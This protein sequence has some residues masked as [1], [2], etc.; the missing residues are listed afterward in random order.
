MTTSQYLQ[1]P[2]SRICD[3]D[4]ATLALIFHHAG[5]SHVNLW[6]THPDYTTL[7]ACALVARTWRRPAQM[8]LYRHIR[9]HS[10]A[11]ML[12][13]RSRESRRLIEAFD[14]E[15]LASENQWGIDTYWLLDR[16]GN[17]GSLKGFGIVYDP[18]RGATDGQAQRDE[19]WLAWDIL[20]HPALSRIQSLCCKAE[21]MDPVDTSAIALPLTHLTFGRLP[22][23]HGTALHQ[24]LLTS[25]NSSLH[26]ISLDFDPESASKPALDDLIEYFQTTATT[27]KYL[28]FLNKPNLNFLMSLHSKMNAI[29]MPSFF[30]VTYPLLPKA[31]A[32]FNVLCLACINNG[33]SLVE[34][35]LVEPPYHT[36]QDLPN[37]EEHEALVLR[38]LAAF[39][40]RLDS[41]NIMGRR[42]RFMFPREWSARFTKIPEVAKFIDRASARGCDVWCGTEQRFSAAAKAVEKR[43]GKRVAKSEE[44]NDELAEDTVASDLANAS[45]QNTRLVEETVLQAAVAAS[46]KKKK[47]V[48]KPKVAPSLF[49]SREKDPGKPKGKGKA[50]E[51]GRKPR[52]N[53]STG[54]ARVA[55]GSIPAA[56]GASGS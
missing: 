36:L 25:M 12:A 38:Y 48:A 42:F 1:A 29:K 10:A 20:R 55:D 40:S 56:A 43:K 23:V 9:I 26:T 51:L 6:I 44:G 18:L 54:T 52:S 31:L 34:F 11:S 7:R 49:G 21:F 22:L 17:R 5:L 45:T 8:M 19:D 53:E 32:P 47:A 3:F 14:T 28:H 37:D 50:V 13:I 4:E 16:I 27:L 41:F 39:G 15:Y 46:T 30:S 2:R 24:A 33:T 35:K